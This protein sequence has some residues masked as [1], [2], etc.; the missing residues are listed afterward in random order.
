M[1]H[2][3]APDQGLEDDRKQ[4]A[5]L[6]KILSDRETIA[7]FEKTGM[8]MKFAGAREFARFL[9]EGIARWAVAVRY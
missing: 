6:P 8:T 7:A 2:G 3:R 4:L 9:D 1:A 5:E